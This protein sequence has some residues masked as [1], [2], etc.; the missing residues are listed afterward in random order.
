MLILSWL[1]NKKKKERMNDVP[2]KKKMLYDYTVCGWIIIIIVGCC[3]EVNM[4]KEWGIINLSTPR[5]V[6][7]NG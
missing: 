2:C 4:K 5:H 1:K 7:K 3:C 6:K